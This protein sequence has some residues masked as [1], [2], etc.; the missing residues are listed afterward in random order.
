MRP[1]I[2][3][4]DLVKWLRVTCH[5]VTL[6]RRHACHAHPAYS[7]YLLQSEI[8]GYKSLFVRIK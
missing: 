8:N 1:Q 4:I 5:V 7:L 6:S 3:Q 2:T